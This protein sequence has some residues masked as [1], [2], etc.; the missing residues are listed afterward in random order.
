ML[1][2]KYESSSPY[3]LGQK[4][5]KNFFLYLYVKSK[6]QQHRT[7]FHSR[8]IIWSILVETHWMMLHAKYESSS[9]YGLGQKDFKNFLLYLY[10]KSKTQQHRTNF[11][12]RAIIWSILVEAHWMMLHAKYE[13][14]SPYGLGQKD[15]KNFLLYLYVKS[16]TPQHRTNFHSRAIIWSILVEAH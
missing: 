1:H 7:N 13:S 4:D 14:S 6:T 8:A 11:R 9:P 2:A 16:K 5:F 15:F 3:D 10:V 12:S